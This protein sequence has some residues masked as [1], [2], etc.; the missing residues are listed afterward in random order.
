VEPTTRPFRPEDEAG[1][2]AVQAASFEFDRFDGFTTGDLE[3]ET[4]SIL[5]N[6]G[7]VAVAV[8]RGVLCGYVSP[9]HDD[10]TVHPDFRRRGHGRRLFAEGLRLAAEAG[11]TELSLFVPR[12]DSAEGF[13]RAMGMAYKSS[14]WRFE[15]PS[16]T[17]VAGPAFPPDVAGRAFGEWLS[18]ERYVALMNACFADHASPLWWTAEQIAYAHSQPGFD[19]RD[20]LL[21][22]AAERPDEPVGF[23]RTTLMSP[24]AAGRPSGEVRAIGLLPAWRG[25]GLGRE[26]LRWS[27]AHLRSKSA[28][29]VVLSVEAE[30]DRAV[31][32]Y[33]R[34]GFEPLVE[35]PHWTLPVGAA[36]SR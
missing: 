3:A 24:D 28:G 21:V 35:W 4:I 32:L 11:L 19:P 23:A 1:L 33:L 29:V 12:Q 7:G 9:R 25:R 8:E 18:I 16:G 14:L 27:V 20:V 13:A 6:P 26:L 10:L 5:G 22:A 17:E 2:R 31:E 15:L 34:H 36:R 30:N